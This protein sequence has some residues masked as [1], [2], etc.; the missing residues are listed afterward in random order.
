MTPEQTRFLDALQHLKYDKAF[1]VVRERLYEDA[2]KT[3]LGAVRASDPH[4][5]GRAAG[6]LEIVEMLDKGMATEARKPDTN[7]QANTF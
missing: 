5:N 6:K 3:A 2:H 4:A 1:Q 7:P